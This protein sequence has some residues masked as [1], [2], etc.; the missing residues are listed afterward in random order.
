[1]FTLQQGTKQ[2]GVQGT[3]KTI[4]SF[5]PKKVESRGFK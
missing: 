2:Q 1:M 3:Q 4:L 5:V